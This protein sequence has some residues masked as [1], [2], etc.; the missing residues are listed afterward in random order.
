MPLDNVKFAKTELAKAAEG[1]SRQDSITQMEYIK[2]RLYIAGLSNEDFS[3][4]LRSV[5]FPFEGGDTGTGVE[6]YHGSHGR[7]ETKSPIRTFTA[8]DINGE[9]NLLAAYLCTPLVRIPL[10]QL[11]PGENVKGT[12]IAELGNRNRPID[13]VVYQ[14][15]GKDYILM[16]N[17]TRGLMKIA[18]ENAGSV[19]PI[20]KRIPDKAGVKY[21]T[22]SAYKNN[23]QQ[24]SRLDKENVLV[25]LQ[26]DKGGMDLETIILP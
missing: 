2:G 25:L 1:R 17:S 24:L 22:L 12:T 19:E 16:A 20:T 23:V 13:M 11:K 7:F 15:D 26:N 8:F 14:K 9:T 10:Q 3:S 6:I 21:E 4:K 5:P 18:M